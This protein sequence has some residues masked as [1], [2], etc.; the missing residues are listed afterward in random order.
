MGAVLEVKYFNSFWLKKI[1]SITSVKTTTGIVR[2]DVEDGTIIELEETNTLI[3]VGQQVTGSGIS[4][5]PVPTIVYFD[6]TT[7]ITLSEPQT[8]EAG[9]E[10]TIGPITDFKYIPS[11]Y[12]GDV[13]EGIDW[14]VEET[15]IRGG[16]N[17]T[18]VDLGVKAYTVE[19]TDTQ[20]HRYNS[21][22]Y[23]GIYNSRT[24]IN[25]TNQFSVGQDITKSADPANGSI[26]KLYAENTNLII[27][28]ESKV[29]QALID[30]NAVYS[31][32]GQP[33]TTS[34]AFVIGQIQAY[35]GNYGISTNPE[36]FAVYGYRKYFTDRNQNAV[37]RLSQDGITEI[38][39]YGMLDYFRDYLT[40]VSTTGRVVGMW[41]MHNKQYVL[42]LQIAGDQS[43]SQRYDPT[44]EPTIV[45]DEDVNGWTSRLSFRPELGGSLRNNFYTFRSGGI[46]QHYST[47]VNK[48][49]FYNA[50]INSSVVLIFNSSTSEVKNFNTL[51]YEGSAGWQL[52]SLITDTD[53]AIPVLPF[54]QVY[55]LANIQNQLFSNTF[56]KKENKYFATIINNTIEGAG[57]VIWGQSMTGLKGFYATATMSINNSL[58]GSPFARTELFAASTEYVN[59]SY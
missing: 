45:F 46:W 40:A 33:M 6:G 8:V 27:F 2:Y 58:Y 56:K 9:T 51:N 19:D 50:T 4:T 28:Q 48:G 43:S 14:Y 32:D 57:D 29:S 11:A 41:D 26:Q 23:S 25:N 44:A 49:T 38:S 5:N 42:S 3:G 52:D 18:N 1:K 53:S 12:S 59:S 47:N 7:K 21:I 13:T 10:L 31:A 39:A 54:T 24:G 30:K 22:I 37:L 55:N 15:R 34:G 35:A 16:Y 20:Q 17:N 36:S